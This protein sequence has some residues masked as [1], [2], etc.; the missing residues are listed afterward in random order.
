MATSLTLALKRVGVR[1]HSDD[2][3]FS[4][5]LGGDQ[6]AFSEVYRRYNKA[7]YGYC[8][9]RL[10]ERE[11]AADAAQEV[12]IRLFESPREGIEHPRAWLFTIARNVT[13][14]AIRK[15]ARTPELA[16]GEATERAIEHASTPGAADEFLGR[17]DA[18]NVF[19]AMRRMRPRYRT[20]LILRELHHESSADIADALET[21]PGAVDTLV[22]RARDAFARAY[23][24][25]AGL[26]VGCRDAVMAIYTRKGSGLDAAEEMRLE[27]HLRACTHC[28]KEAARASRP[29]GL[30]ALLP[31]LLPARNTGFN[32]IE[33][34]AHSLSNYPDLAAKLGYALPPERLTPAAK[35]A[36][37]LLVVSLIAAPVVGTVVIRRGTGAPSHPSVATSVGGSTGAAAGANWYGMRS[38]S[39]WD[40]Q[41]MRSGWEQYGPWQHSGSWYGMNEGSWSAWGSSGPTRGS[42]SGSSSGMTSDERTTKLSSSWSSSS[43]GKSSGSMTSHRSRSSG[44]SW[45]P[46]RSSGGSWSRSGS[47]SS[48]SMSS[49]S[50]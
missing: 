14:D 34:A 7:V 43:G 5:A 1:R 23:G 48:S 12:F 42:W 4:L 18:R 24:E 50:W 9:A 46:S 31:F 32:L 26:P 15:R 36:A 6:V 17:E 28:R 21:T 49:G 35:I 33:R 11:A 41:R 8:L 25:V 38:S 22:S 13:I 3:V 40:G 30:A 47:G 45:S 39:V 27:S 16:D 37:G 44:S 20:A 10:M 19:L 2:E 29:N